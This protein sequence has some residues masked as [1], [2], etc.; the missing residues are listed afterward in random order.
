MSKMERL[1]HGNLMSYKFYLRP[2][3]HK[4]YSYSTRLPSRTIHQA[5]V[6][7]L[8]YTLFV[9]GTSTTWEMARARHSAI[10]EIRTQEK[11]YRR[12]LV[13]R[14][15]RK[16][17]SNGIIDLGLVVPAEP[18]P[19]IGGG[20]GPRPYARYRLSLY[21]IL[22][23]MDAFEPEKKD[24]DA[25]ASAYEEHLPRVFG[26]WRDLK[27]VAGKRVYCLDVLAK[28]LYLN[29]PSVA[30][31]GSPIYELMSFLH[32]IYNRKFESIS[33]YDLAEQ[34]SYWF[35]TFLW[36]SGGPVMLKKVLDVDQGLRAWYWDFFK[37]AKKYYGDRLRAMKEPSIF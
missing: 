36:H 12:L 24:I 33:E 9:H 32:V 34:I 11:A 17:R 3:I 30:D 14:T 22:Y 20:E 7:E 13:G 29:N 2:A 28:G 6:H 5:S 27:R 18:A 4:I 26:R 35:Y 23:C 8:L 15:D 25:A 31:D 19:R 1:G 16:K 21:G 10:N 37:R